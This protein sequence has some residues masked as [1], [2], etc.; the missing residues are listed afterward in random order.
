MPRPRGLAR[1]KEQGPGVSG[2]SWKFTLQSRPSPSPD[3]VTVFAIQRELGA[4]PYLYL[5]SKGSQWLEKIVG[6]RQS[7]NTALHCGPV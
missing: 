1:S 6:N 7:D 4:R 3:C 5:A 2:G